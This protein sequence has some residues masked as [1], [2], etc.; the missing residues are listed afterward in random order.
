MLKKTLKNIEESL[1]MKKKKVIVI[2]KRFWK[3]RND[4]FFKMGFNNETIK[5]LR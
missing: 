3:I 4:R 2:E 5:R 1:P